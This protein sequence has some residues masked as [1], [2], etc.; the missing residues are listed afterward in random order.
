MA[1][2]GESTTE[3]TPPPDPHEQFR[4]YCR[5]RDCARIARGEMT[6]EAVGR[7]EAREF[8]RRQREER[9]REELEEM[10]R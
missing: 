2:P 4:A 9:V 6:P 7:L 8:I 1:A 3:T 5:A 10:T